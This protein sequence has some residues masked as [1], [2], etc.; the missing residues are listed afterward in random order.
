[1][2]YQL[3]EASRAF[4]AAL[5]KTDDASLRE[6]FQRLATEANDGDDTTVYPSA[7]IKSLLCDAMQ[8]EMEYRSDV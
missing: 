4:L 2:N 5:R 8:K 6:T 3:I 1:M 7:E